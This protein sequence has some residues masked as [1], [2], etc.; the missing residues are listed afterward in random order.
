MHIILG[1]HSWKSANTWVARRMSLRDI[2]LER[3]LEI[4]PWSN[5]I[6]GHTKKNGFPWRNAL[7][8]S[9]P[10]RIP[11]WQFIRPSLP[12]WLWLHGPVSRQAIP[13]ALGWLVCH[14]DV[15]HA[16]LIFRAT[17]WNTIRSN[18]NR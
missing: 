7:K 10:E 8:T 18:G 6:Y 2:E 4:P 14:N 12:E 9:Y 11:V 16:L 1:D 15:H 13:H 17:L 3:N 5:V